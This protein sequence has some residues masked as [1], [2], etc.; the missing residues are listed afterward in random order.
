VSWFQRNGGSP[1]LRQA[2]Q[3]ALDASGIVAAIHAAC[4]PAGLRRFILRFEVRHGRPVLV[5]AD[6]MR[7]P[8]GGGPP[9]GLDDAGPAIEAALGRLRSRLPA[10][11]TFSSGAVGVLR[12]ADADPIVSFRLDEDAEGYALAGLRMPRGPTIAV[13]APDYQKALAAWSARMDAVRQRWIRP[14]ED[15]SLTDGRLRMGEEVVSVTPF[16][17]WHAG[18]SRWEWLVEKPVSAESPCVE[19]EMVVPLGPAMELAAFAAA[20]MGGVG[21]FQGEAEG[22]LTVFGAVRA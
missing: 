16:A 2:L 9:P 17:T 3:H 21:V 10:G 4:G 15:W 11:V 13:E 8:G 14:R 22:G 20:R 19:P 12:D 6:A 18:Q 5:G 7:L 1:E